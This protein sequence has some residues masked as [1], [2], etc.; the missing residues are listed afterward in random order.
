MQYHEGQDIL[1]KLDSQHLLQGLYA[2]RVE[3]KEVK[4]ALLQA[5]K[6]TCDATGEDWRGLLFSLGL[7]AYNSEIEKNERTK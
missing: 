6:A 1:L 4:V 7:H 5:L 3:P 2:T